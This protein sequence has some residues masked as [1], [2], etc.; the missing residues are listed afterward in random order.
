ML[1]CKP[2][3]LVV[4]LLLRL[5]MPMRSVIDIVLLY[6][7]SHSKEFPLQRN[8]AYLI[9]GDKGAGQGDETGEEIGEEG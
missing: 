9:S 1:L 7:V 5:G 8:W 2:L 3:L 6:L 4:N